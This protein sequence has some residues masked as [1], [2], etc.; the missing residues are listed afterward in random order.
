MRYDIAELSGSDLSAE[1]LPDEVDP[2]RSLMD[3]NCGSSVHDRTLSPGGTQVTVLLFW[4]CLVT[5]P[6]LSSSL[7]P[8]SGERLLGLTAIGDAFQ[9]VLICSGNEASVCVAQ[10]LSFPC[11]HLQ[12]VESIHDLS[13]CSTTKM[14]CLPRVY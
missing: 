8:S 3:A 6:W 10:S 7:V 13:P 2:L 14:L 9:K 12:D 11:L 1:T 5:S 4:Q